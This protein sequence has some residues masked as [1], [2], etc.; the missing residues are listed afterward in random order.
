[1]CFTI[2]YFLNKYMH[3]V[4]KNK[5]GKA[6]QFLSASKHLLNSTNSRLTQEVDVKVE[7]PKNKK[8]TFL[9]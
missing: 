8:E 9:K 6:F 5:V 4:C 7:I 2:F 1:M 3:P